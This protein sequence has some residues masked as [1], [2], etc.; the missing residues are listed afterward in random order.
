MAI[1]PACGCN[2]CTFRRPIFHPH[3]LLGRERLQ[4]PHALQ[5][6][7]RRLDRQ[8]V[9]VAVERALQRGD[10]VG[11]QVIERGQRVLHLTLGPRALDEGG[12][13]GVLLPGGERCRA[14]RQPTGD[15]RRARPRRE[16]ADRAADA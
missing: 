4:L 7:A 6:L 3:S 1:C 5:D 15:L 9:V 12:E 16:L 10:R 8:P 2:R 11:Q 14:Q 13:V